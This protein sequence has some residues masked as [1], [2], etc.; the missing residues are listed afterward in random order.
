MCISRFLSVVFVVV[1]AKN[2]QHLNVFV[3]DQHA[4]AAAAAW[5]RTLSRSEEM[6][7]NE[8]L[9]FH[10]LDYIAQREEDEDNF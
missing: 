10:G 3:C 7:C 5:T 8:A 4:A 2:P 6:T 1:V 9:S